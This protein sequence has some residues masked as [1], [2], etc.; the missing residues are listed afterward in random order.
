MICKLTITVTFSIF[1]QRQ[2]HW[3]N[4]ESGS[5]ARTFSVLSSL[6]DNATE[7]IGELSCDMDLS[8]SVCFINTIHTI[9]CIPVYMS[10]FFKVWPLIYRGSAHVP[11]PVRL[12][13]VVQGLTS[14]YPFLILPLSL[15]RPDKILSL[16]HPLVR[17]LLLC[18]QKLA[19]SINTCV[20]KLLETLC[21][22]TL[23]NSK[24]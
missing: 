14:R 2:E 8:S 21:F 3:S 4:L 9:H 12:K 19:V 6:E 23:I 16:I 18:V 11:Q 5:T 24:S 13:G 22:L 1:Q 15:E 7:N 20:V 10:V 17:R